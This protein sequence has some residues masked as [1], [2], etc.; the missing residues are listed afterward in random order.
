MP[1]VAVRLGQKKNHRRKVCSANAGGSQISII[2]FSMCP[3]PAIKETFFGAQKGKGNQKRIM[4]IKLKT[5]IAAVFSV[6][7]L[8]VFGTAHAADVTSSH[9]YTYTNCVDMNVCY[10][11]AI[12]DCRGLNLSTAMSPVLED[13]M[14]NKVYGDK[15]IDPD[16]VTKKG[17][18]G[19]ATCFTDSEALA[20]AGSNPIILRAIAIG[21]NNANPVIDQ[22]DAT[23]VKYSIITNN[24][25]RNAA[26]VFVR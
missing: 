22:A 19:Y 3:T 9:T 12:I 17:M 26:V 18:V 13:T 10:T 21:H 2:V 20:R 5:F 24:Y 15:Y 25:F 16:M 4:D 7:S 8:G 1:N 23:L 11:G 6:I 14:G